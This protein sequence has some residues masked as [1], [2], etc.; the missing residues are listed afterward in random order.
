MQTSMRAILL[1]AA[2]LSA[3]GLT[4]NAKEPKL[5]AAEVVKKHLESIGP[6][7]MRAAIRT[8]VIEGRTRMKLEAGAVGPGASG[9][10]AGTL[11]LASAGS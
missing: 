5:K 7:R 9:M 11:A 8:R 2:V 1:S 4:L 6:A 10:L 3:L